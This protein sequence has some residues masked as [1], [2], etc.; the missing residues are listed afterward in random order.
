MASAAA[1][2]VAALGMDVLLIERKPV[3]GEPVQSGE[4]LP[5]GAA[6]GRAQVLGDARGFTLA[7]GAVSVFDLPPEVVA[8]CVLVLRTWWWERVD[9]VRRRRGRAG[10]QDPLPGHPGSGGG[11]T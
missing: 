3:P 10:R 1:W 4:W 2:R 8:R 9:P 7:P 6:V 5:A 11:R